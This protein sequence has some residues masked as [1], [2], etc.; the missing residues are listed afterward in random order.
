MSHTLKLPI[1]LR[2]RIDGVVISTKETTGAKARMPACTEHPLGGAHGSKP[3]KY[4]RENVVGSF[5][6]PGLNCG[7]NM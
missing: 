6:L 7:S 1:G 2:Y 3:I 4:V 5:L